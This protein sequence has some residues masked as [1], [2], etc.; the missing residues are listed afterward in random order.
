MA[1]NEMKSYNAVIDTFSVDIPMGNFKDIT[2]LN[3]ENKNDKETFKA[4]NYAKRTDNIEKGI[5]HLVIKVHNIYKTKEREIYIESYKELKE[6]LRNL[7]SDMEVQNMNELTMPRVDIAVDRPIG[8]K[9]GFKQ[10]LY[11]FELITY[12]SKKNT[13][14]YTTN[15]DTLKRNSIRLSN[16]S[17]EVCFYDKEEESCGKFPYKTRLEF[18]LKR[19]GTNNIDVAVDKLIEKLSSIDKNIENVTNDMTQRLIKLWEME[20]KE[21]ANL[22]FTAFVS[23]HKDYFYNM[24]ILKGL[25]KYV[26]LKSAVK[27]WLDN[28][29]RTNDIEFLSNKQIITTK[30][31]I[32]REIKRYKKS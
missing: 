16:N 25:Y 31:D 4:L 18:R 14:W 20:K 6:I 2:K 30:K 15:V 5:I 24:E 28:F 27:K 22:T 1:T 13:R 21:K 26:G 23:Y 29:K 10:H 32:I 9:E 19:L 3:E 7:Y 8:F 17:F 11:L 12:G